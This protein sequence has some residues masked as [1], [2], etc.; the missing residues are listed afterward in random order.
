MKAQKE[1]KDKNEKGTEYT[2][3]HPET[4]SNSLLQTQT[5]FFE[6]LEI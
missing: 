3:I 2:L 5:S 6:L 4:N 1:N